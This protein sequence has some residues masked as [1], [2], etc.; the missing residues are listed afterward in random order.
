MVLNCESNITYVLN[1][2]NADII[3]LF[4]FLILVKCIFNFGNRLIDLK[5]EVIT[6]FQRRLFPVG[7]VIIKF[8]GR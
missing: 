8:T 1:K 4:L 7:W 2:N 3:A 5:Y 6:F